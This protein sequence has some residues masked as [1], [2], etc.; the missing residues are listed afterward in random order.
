MR[1]VKVIVVPYHD[2][3]ADRLVGKGPDRL[4]AV[5]LVKALQAWGD[6]IEVTYV[7]PVDAFAGVVD[8]SFALQRRVAVTVANAV[9][10]G[11]FPLV[12]AG[13]CNTT[14]GVHAGMSGRNAGI[15][16]FDAHADIATP[17]ECEGGYFDSMGVATLTGHCWQ[18]LARTIPGFQPLDPARLIY[19]GLRDLDP[20]HAAKITRLGIPVVAGSTTGPVDFAGKLDALLDRVPLEQAI[21]HLDLD[22]LDTSVGRANQYALPGGLST[23]DLASCLATTCSHVQ[24]VAMT[25][26]SFDPDCDGSERI[27]AA[28]IDAAAYV[29]AAAA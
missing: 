22:C 20:I 18:D 16:W 28:A 27:A 9:R 2:G 15:V 21:I 17:D 11:A 25:I 3:V 26:A 7:P 8:R 24:P 19:S 23:N 29:C 6:R 10:D 5:G 13:N 4:L 14:V 12:L 1:D